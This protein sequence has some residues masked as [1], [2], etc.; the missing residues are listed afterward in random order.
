METPY[1][2]APCTG[3]F[4]EIDRDAQAKE[5]SIRIVLYDSDN[6]DITVALVAIPFDAFPMVRLA[7]DNTITDIQADAWAE[8]YHAGTPAKPTQPQRPSEADEANQAGKLLDRRGAP[9]T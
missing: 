1:S 9:S 5:A 7:L 2:V 6:N 3:P 8:G 4:L